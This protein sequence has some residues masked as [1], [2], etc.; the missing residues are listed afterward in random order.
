MSGSPSEAEIQTQWQNAVDIL[1]TTRVFVDETLAADDGKFDTLLK[2]LEGD[3][4][5]ADLANAVGRYQAG[6]SGL[7]SPGTTLE[8]MTPLVFEYG[9]ILSGDASLGFGSG[10]RDVSSLFRALYEWF[11]AKSLTVQSRDITYDTSAT[12]GGSNIGN[13]AMSRLT[14]DDENF[15]LEA[16]H[17]EKKAFRCRSDQNTGVDENA[18]V[19]EFLGAAAGPDSLLRSSFGSGDAAHSSI[20]SHHAG[21]GS[22][23]SLLTNSSFSEYSA[24]GTPKFTAWTETAVPASSIS[25]DTTADHYYRTH[26]GSQTDGSLKITCNLGDVTL[27]Q[28]IDN[29]RVRRLD[30]NT[31]YFLRIMWNRSVGSGDGT[32]AI[33]MGSKSVTVVLAAQSGW[34][35]LLITPSQDSW[36]RHFNEDPM[37]IEISL[38]SSST[39]YVLIDDVLFAPYD[40][41]DGTY[42][43]LRGN[44]ATH[45]P[46]LIDDT[47]TFTDT[48]GA[49]AT[50]KIQYWLF[51]AGLGY[52]PHTTGTPTFTDP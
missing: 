18:E 47:L 20:R 39:G 48:G 38:T 27:K 23:G 9:K 25:Q 37:D 29:M 2:S 40:L 36:F 22:G 7:V 45:T 30:P 46:W 16:C 49:P 11:V 42:W 10:Y 17:I 6:C 21:S 8:F 35:E 3:Y 28:T 15:D 14:V 5:P 12:A 51:V 31:P 32:L 44:A 1:E 33:K 4:T 24:T 41:I 19:F 13:G 50:A 43:F 26:P 52:L 34:Q